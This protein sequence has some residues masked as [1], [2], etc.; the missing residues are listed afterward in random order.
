VTLLLAAATLA[1]LAGRAEAYPQLQFSTG[2]DRCSQC[3][4]SPGGGGLLTEYGRD[5]LTGLSQLE[6]GDGR[7]LHG[8]WTAPA[9][10]QLGGDFRF[11]LGARRDPIGVFGEPES[12]VGPARVEGMAFPM[13]GDLYVRPA[14]G[15]VSLNVTVGGR[16]AREDPPPAER[17][18]SREHYLMYQPVEDA[19]WYVRAGRF[20]PVFG[21]RTQDHTA[22]VRRHLDMYLMAEPYG[23]GYGRYGDTWEL[24]ASAFG[25][26]PAPLLGTAD[27]YGAALYVERR[28]ADATGSLAAQTRFTVGELDKQW[29]VGGVARR[30]FEGAQVLLL[31][32]ADLGVQLLDQPPG[33]GLAPRVQAVA[34]VSATRTLRQGLWLGGVAQ[35]Y[36]PDVSLAQTS[37]EAVEANLQWFPIPHVELHLLTRAETVGLDGDDI[38]LLA[39]LQLHYVL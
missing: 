31:A 16:A 13:Q 6:V 20:Y 5:E 24:H 39:L 4:Y 38:N 32:E 18:G 11:A 3:H 14:Y 21:V 36:D 10:L 9:W 19:R 33:G 35:V 1:A 22:Y 17:L 2:A 23:V 29:V 30:W 37:R 12:V 27:D 15:P 25:P 34:Y 28:N 7:L 8:A 26:A